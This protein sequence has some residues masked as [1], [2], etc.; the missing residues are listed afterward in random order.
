MSDCSNNTLQVHDLLKCVSMSDTTPGY[1]NLEKLI[2]EELPTSVHNR[3]CPHGSKCYSGNRIDISSIEILPKPINTAFDMINEKDECILFHGTPLKNISSILSQGLR[4]E[5][6]IDPGFGVG[7]YM[8]P[9]LKLARGFISGDGGVFVC[10]VKLGVCKIFHDGDPNYV[11]EDQ[12][13]NRLG[14]EFVIYETSR[15]RPIMLLRFQ[16]DFGPK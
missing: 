9:C 6:C 13:S 7:V 5:C 8:T 2:S 15:I 11:R 4:P 10:R 3:F 1:V 16:S 14:D 12:N